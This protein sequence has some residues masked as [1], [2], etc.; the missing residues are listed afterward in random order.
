[1]PLLEPTQNEMFEPTLLEDGTASAV[2]L[3]HERASNDSDTIFQ[4]Q[5]SWTMHW[6]E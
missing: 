6:L 3:C 5:A 1:M 2:P 4:V